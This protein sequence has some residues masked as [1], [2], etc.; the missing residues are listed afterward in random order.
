MLFL[1]WAKES[2]WKLYKFMFRTEKH[3]TPL[4]RFWGWCQAAHHCLHCHV[5]ETR[6]FEGGSWETRTDAASKAF[7]TSKVRHYIAPIQN[8]PKW[9]PSTFIFYRSIGC[10]RVGFWRLVAI[11]LPPDSH[12]CSSWIFS[13]F[14]SFWYLQRAVSIEMSSSVF[15]REEETQT[16]R[17]STCFLK[18]VTTG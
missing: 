11:S 12:K 4:A 9:C 8:P 6:V 2:S 18:W 3:G 1:L 7:Y 13:K 17:I 10:D 16:L 15:S 5:R 14:K